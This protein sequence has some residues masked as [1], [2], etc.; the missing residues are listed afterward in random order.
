[1][2][3]KRQAFPEFPLS[4]S[5]MAR[6][7]FDWTRWLL[8]GE[9]IQDSLW[10]GEEGI[11]VGAGNITHSICT[12]YVSGGENGKFYRLTNTVTTA[13]AQGSRVKSRTMILACKP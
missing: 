9:T 6:Y 10:T 7:G 3:I 12:T 2:P 11:V 8:D 4:P 1:M 5:G 13:S